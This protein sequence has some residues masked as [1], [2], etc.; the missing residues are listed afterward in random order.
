MRIN[1]HEM[2]MWNAYIASLRSTCN[3]AQ[4][5][6]VIVQDGRVVSSGYAGAPSGLPH[7]GP[8]C[9]LSQPCDRTVHAEAGAITYAARVGISTQGATLYCTH[10]PC[11]ECAKLIINSGIQNVYYE[12]PYRKKEGLQLLDQAGVL[13]HQ[14]TRSELPAVRIVRDREDGLQLGIRYRGSDGGLGGPNSPG[15]LGR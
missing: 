4:V 11:L 1:R 6:A 10:C 15:G 12:T 3:R 2:H 14:W 13:I 5:G 7:C 9:N 8:E